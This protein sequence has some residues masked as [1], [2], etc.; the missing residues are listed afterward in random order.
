[1]MSKLNSSLSIYVR[2]AKFQ[3]ANYKDK[4]KTKLKLLRLI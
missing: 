2:H 4:G 1:M 3:I